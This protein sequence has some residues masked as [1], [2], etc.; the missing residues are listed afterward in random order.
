VVVGRGGNDVL[1]RLEQ[2][3]DVVG[4]RVVREG[5]AGRVEDDV[6]V[7]GEDR[8]LVIGGEQPGRRSADE[9]P[10]VRTDLVSAVDENADELEVRAIDDVLELGRTD[11]AGRPLDDPRG[12]GS[13][14]GSRRPSMVPCRTLRLPSGRTRRATRN[15]EPIHPWRM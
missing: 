9:R 14:G 8:V 5:L 7:E 4:V 6:G 3:D 2:G 12:H 15:S 13:C 1:P 10:G 11:R